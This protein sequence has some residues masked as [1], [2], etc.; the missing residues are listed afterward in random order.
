ML[1]ANIRAEHILRI[2]T[3]DDYLKDTGQTEAAFAAKAGLS[4]PR[5]NRIRR[6]ANTS[7][8][9]IRR[10]CEASDW[11]VTPDDIIHRDGG[12]E[13]ARGTPAKPAEARP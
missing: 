9:T 4:Q 12:S 8:A 1:D 7:G 13:P 11:R 3:L 2:M 10:I 6:G 5:L